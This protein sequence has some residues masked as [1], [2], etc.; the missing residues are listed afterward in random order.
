MEEL[1][2]VS[3]RPEFLN[4]LDDIV[5]YKPLSKVEISSVVDLLMENLRRRLQ[6]KQLDL[7]LTPRAKEYVID[8]GYD[9]IYG[10]RPLKRFIQSRIET[11][12]ARMMIAEDLAP[13]TRLTVDYRDGDLVVYKD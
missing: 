11:L 8:E 6:E 13:D 4:R 10:A 1:L 3:F 5:F 9:P 12:I 2:K 7:V